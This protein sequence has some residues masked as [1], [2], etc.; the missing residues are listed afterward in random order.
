MFPDFQSGNI[1]FINHPLSLVA[2]EHEEHEEKCLW[3]LSE[4]QLPVFVGTRFK[5]LVRS[6]LRLRPDT[7]MGWAWGRVTWPE[8]IPK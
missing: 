4:G 7:H 6:S 2:E 8:I 3:Q 1:V 5:N